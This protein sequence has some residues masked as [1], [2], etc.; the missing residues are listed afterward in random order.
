MLPM[1]LIAGLLLGGLVHRSPRLAAAVAPAAS[2]LWGVGVGVANESIAT[3][4]AGTLL[5]AVNVAL[6]M[7]VGGLVGSSARTLG[8]SRPGTDRSQP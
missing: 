3:F 6:G 7:L 2:V 5:A 8:H 1:H 4:A